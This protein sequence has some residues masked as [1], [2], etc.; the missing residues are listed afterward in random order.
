MNIRKTSRTSYAGAA[1]RRSVLF[2]I[3]SLL[4]AATSTILMADA[5]VTLFVRNNVTYTSQP[6]LVHCWSGDDDIGKKNVS[7][8]DEYAF[9]FGP[10]LW[11][12]FWCNLEP[13]TNWHAYFVAWE[14]GYGDGIGSYYWYAGDDGVHGR[15]AVRG[16]DLHTW[17][18]EHN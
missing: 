4:S 5:M 7:F 17:E 8:G 10:L 15:T 18:W 16:E 14:D 12:K 11:T 6:L 2:I 13:D 1:G 3:I 9:S